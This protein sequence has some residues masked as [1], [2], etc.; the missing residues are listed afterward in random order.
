M[1]VK[2]ITEDK[3]DKIVKAS[4]YIEFKWFVWRSH[5]KALVKFYTP[6]NAQK[7]YDSLTQYPVL[8]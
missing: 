3:S 8:D 7:A 6:E 1:D 5:Q 2:P 4:H